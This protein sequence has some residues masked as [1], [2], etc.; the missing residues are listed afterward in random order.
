MIELSHRHFTDGGLGP[1]NNA[2]LRFRLGNL[3][4][5]CRI[6]VVD[7]TVFEACRQI[8]VGIPVVSAGFCPVGRAFGPGTIVRGELHGVHAW[9]GSLCVFWYCG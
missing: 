2:H 4:I 1:S 9:S 6:S 7:S 5:F 3:V 8:K